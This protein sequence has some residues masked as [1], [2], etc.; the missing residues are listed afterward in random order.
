MADDQS[1]CGKGLAAS[2]LLPERLA[3]LMT[4]M[5]AV[6]ENHLRALDPGEMSG[7][8]EHDAYVRLVR[9]QRTLASGLEALG[10]AMAGYRDLPG[11]K[12]DMLSLTDQTSRDL[13]S[14]FI[15]AEEEALRLLQNRVQEHRAMLSEMRR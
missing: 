12:H 9:E 10:R 11:A 13:L 6:L 15:Q 2:A 14:A 1:T 5:A 7:R 3:A 4:S 8:I